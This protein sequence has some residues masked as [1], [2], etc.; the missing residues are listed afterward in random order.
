MCPQRLLGVLLERIG[1]VDASWSALGDLLESSWMTL[2]RKKANL[3]RLLAA[4]KEFQERFQPPWGPKCFQ[5]GGR[6]GAK[7]RSKS[8]SS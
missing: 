5:K 7:S 4:P 2:G 8:G 6:E 1:L 3:E